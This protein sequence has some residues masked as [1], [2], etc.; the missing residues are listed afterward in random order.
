M[1]SLTQGTEF[2]S[3]NWILYNLQQKLQARN[4]NIKRAM[5][6]LLTGLLLDQKVLKGLTIKCQAV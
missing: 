4:S 6:E 1:A 5:Q 2:Y 3:A